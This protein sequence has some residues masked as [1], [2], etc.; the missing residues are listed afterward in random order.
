MRLE[1]SQEI[2]LAQAMTGEEFA[3][4]RHDYDRRRDRILPPW[5]GMQITWRRQRAATYQ[6]MLDDGWVFTPPAE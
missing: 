4:I 2:S 5:E 1:G 6:A 3:R